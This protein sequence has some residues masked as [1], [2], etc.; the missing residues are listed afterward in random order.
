MTVTILRELNIHYEKWHS[1]D[2]DMLGRDIGEVMTALVEA[3][4][5]WESQEDDEI[6]FKALVWKL[7][8]WIDTTENREFFEI[9]YS[10]IN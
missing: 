7:T 4:A 3:D 8:K 2:I 6:S 9:L 1:T 10:K 5:M